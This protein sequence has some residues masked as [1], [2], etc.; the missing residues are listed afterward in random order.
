MPLWDAKGLLD[1]R[2]CEFAGLDSKPCVRTLQI[3]EP[4]AEKYANE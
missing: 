2:K 4:C 1:L 3:L